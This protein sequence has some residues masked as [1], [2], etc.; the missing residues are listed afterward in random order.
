MEIRQDAV[1]KDKDTYSALREQSEAE[2]DMVIAKLEAQAKEERACIEEAMEKEVSSLKGN[3]SVSE[4]R[5]VEEEQVVMGRYAVDHEKS[6]I[7]QEEVSLLESRVVGMERRVAITEESLKKETD[8]AFDVKKEAQLRID[9]LKRGQNRGV[10]LA[11][12]EIERWELARSEAT[13]WESVSTVTSPLPPPTIFSNAENKTYH[14]T[15]FARRSLK[16]QL[17]DLDVTVS[18]FG[19]VHGKELERMERRFGNELSS[20]EDRV[21]NVLDRKDGVIKD[22][23][24]EVAR[25]KEQSERLSVELDACRKADLVGA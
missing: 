7:L 12:R 18:D 23:E 3:L 15:R 2:L 11:E 17:Q 8:R 20:V 1:R 24:G 25:G 19:S 10:E 6:Q 16:K 14:A 9:G 4:D 5:A 22:L 21:K 13:S